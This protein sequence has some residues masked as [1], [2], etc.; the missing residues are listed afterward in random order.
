MDPAGSSIEFVRD[1]Q[2][3]CDSYHKPS[4][5]KH[6]NVFMTRD[7]PIVYGASTATML[8]T[9]AMAWF[10]HHA[11]NWDYFVPLT[12]SDYPLLPLHRIEKIFTYQQPPRPFVMAWTPGT[13][14]HLFRLQKTHPVFETHPKLVRSIEAVTAERGKVLGAV[15]MEYRS[16]NFGPPLFC[17][18]RSSFYHLDIRFNKTASK[19]ILD[20]QWLFPRDVFP[21]RGRAYAEENP[22]H[23][24]LPPDKGWR[25]WK[26][27]DPATTG[28]Y[29]KRSVAYIVDSIEG[30]KYWHFF[31]HMLLGS[32]EH[33]YVSLLYNWPRT[34][35]FVQ[36]LSAQI[37]WN[38]W[39]LGIWEQAGGFQT[40]T[41]FLTLN[42]WDILEGFSLRGMMFARKFSSRKTGALLDRIDSQLLQNASSQAGL[43][44]PGFYEVDTYASGKY[45]VAAYRKN[46]SARAMARK[47]GQD[48]LPMGL[49]VAN[50]S[51]SPT[52]SV[53]S[54][55]VSS[56]SASSPESQFVNINK[57]VSGTSTRR[58]RKKT[59]QLN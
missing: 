14:T 50:V 25:I 46:A 19:G 3:L 23:A 8:L 44:W 2:A 29:D 6:N 37:V 15:P 38:T 45:W 28:A 5:R 41:H 11:S 40:H 48:M 51:Q 17:S 24:T 26:K 49:F 54:S 36:T 31:K 58:R 22:A 35:A 1:V 18:N 34:R 30:R 16:G 32:E 53:S 9:R 55:S 7:V 56:P 4:V 27:S 42:E 47:S 20:T 57:G 10:L 33:Y 39:E 13:S 43:F 21:G 52:A 12:G 59:S